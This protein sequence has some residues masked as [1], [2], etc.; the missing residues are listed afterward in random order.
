MPVS[1]CK[2]LFAPTWCLFFTAQTFKAEENETTV[3]SC[4]FGALKCQHGVAESDNRRESCPHL[5]HCVKQG[6]SG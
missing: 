3:A 6:S 1:G 2:I 5:H 4:G